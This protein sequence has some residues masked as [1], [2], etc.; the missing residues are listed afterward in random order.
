MSSRDAEIWRALEPL[1]Y[2]GPTTEVV[3]RGRISYHSDDADDVVVAHRA[4]N[5]ARI[6]HADGTPLMLTDGITTW[7]FTDEGVISSPHRDD[8]AITCGAGALAFRRT[9]TEVELFSF[10]TPVGPIDATTYLGRRAWRFAFAAPPH[11]PSDMQVIV[12][13]ETGFVLDRRFAGGSHTRWL[14]FAIGAQV[15]PALFRW[16]G[17]ALDRAE[18]RARRDREHEQ[19]MA[20]RAR[21]FGEHVAARLTFAGREVEVTLHEWDDDGSFQASLD[22]GFDGS[23]ARRP[24]SRDRWELGWSQVHH[25]WSDQRWDWA[26]SSFGDDPVDPD[27]VAAFQRQLSSAGP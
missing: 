5:R 22:N 19:D 16:D 6:E 11:K 10:G 2:D 7:Y 27:G 24:R 13:A 4:G 1:V 15:D 18:L 12:D 26:L 17:P 21:W 14:E 20:Q 23:L 3:V 9:R 25:R 8:D